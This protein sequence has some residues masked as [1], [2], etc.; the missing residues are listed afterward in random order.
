[1][2]APTSGTSPL[3]LLILKFLGPVC[4]RR[5]YKR[6]IEV[7]NGRSAMMGILGLMVHEET[8]AAGGNNP[9]IGLFGAYK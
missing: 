2:T 8:V 7:N 9:V 1:M 5:I 4:L 6:G 3:K